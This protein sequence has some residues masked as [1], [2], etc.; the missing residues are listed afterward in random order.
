MALSCLSDLVSHK[1]AAMYIVYMGCRT[2]G[3]IAH[4]HGSS[5]TVPDSIIASPCSLG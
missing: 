3:L 2:D 4:I 1:Y 5:V